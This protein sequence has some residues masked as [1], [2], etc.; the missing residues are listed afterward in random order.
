[1]IF[2]KSTLEGDFF[3]IQVPNFIPNFQT[4][5]KVGDNFNSLLVN[6]LEFEAIWSKTFYLTRPEK[7]WWNRSP[8]EQTKHPYD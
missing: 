8:S 6:I 5:R 1:M 4:H 3:F 7:Y 2:K